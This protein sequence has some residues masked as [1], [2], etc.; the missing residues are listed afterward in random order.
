M[1]KEQLNGRIPAEVDIHGWI[2]LDTSIMPASIPSADLLVVREPTS[3]DP[4][5]AVAEKWV[6]LR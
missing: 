5:F 2:T 4:V 6:E 1:D 3:L